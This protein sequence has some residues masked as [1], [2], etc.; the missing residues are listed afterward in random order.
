MTIACRVAMA[1][2]AQKE[3]VVLPGPQSLVR[4]VAD[5]LLN[6]I[7]A[8]NG[9]PAVCLAGGSTPLLLYRTLAEPP[10]RD[11]F[12]WQRIHWF[13]G[14]ERFVRW[15][16]PRSNYH[17]ARA[18]LFDHVPAPPENIHPIATT[19]SLDQAAAS[20]DRV[21]RQFYGAS[22]LSGDHPLFA[23]TLLGVGTDGHT[24]SLFPQSPA[25]NERTHWVAAVPDAQPEPR[26]SLTL[27]ALASSSEIAFLVS[28]ASKRAILTRI[29]RGDDLPATRVDTA[30]RI[31]WFVDRAA[32]DASEP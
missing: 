3:F 25:L 10:W 1:K 12:P 29:R 27:P 32:V 24:A 8:T 17:M 6:R 2:S 26:I 11:R 19:G 9:T 13:W 23:A 4:C 22:R 31:H 7:L 30:G 14:D 18:A 5:W 16:D 21:L 28:G 20:Y 15:N